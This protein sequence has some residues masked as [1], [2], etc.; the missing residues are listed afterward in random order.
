MK[1]I[2]TCKWGSPK[3]LKRGE[4]V[5]LEHTASKGVARKIACDHLNESP[6]YYKELLKMEKRLR[7]NLKR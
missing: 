1:G 4:K 3:Q 5:E 2:K 6:D 7:Q